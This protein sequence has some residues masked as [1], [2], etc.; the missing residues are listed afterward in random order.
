MA[1]AS[2]A[3]ASAPEPEE[4]YAFDAR[5]NKW[6]MPATKSPIAASLRPA[7]WSYAEWMK[8]GIGALHFVGALLYILLRGSSAPEAGSKWLFTLNFVVWRLAYNVG[9]GWLL[10]HQSNGGW[11]TE[12][13]EKH[14]SGN[15]L[16]SRLLN[17]MERDS[18]QAGAKNSADQYPVTFRSWLAFRFFVDAILA[19][20][21]AA[22]AA[23]CLVHWEVPSL[24]LTTVLAYAIGGFLCFFGLWAKMDS[25]R[26]VRDFAWYWGDFFFLLHSG[27]ELTFD[28]VFMLSPHP[29]YTIGYSFFYGAALITQSHTVLYVSLLGHLCQLAFLQYVENPH[30]EKIYPGVVTHKDVVEAKDKFKLL[31]EAKE[32]YFRRD[33]IA[34]KNFNPVR[35]SDVAL[36]VLLSYNVVT[37]FVCV[38]LHTESNAPYLKLAFGIH[39]LLWRF[40]LSGGLGY[41]LHLQSTR[42]WFVKRFDTPQ[43]AFES[44]KQLY[45]MT[46]VMSYT[47]FI[48]AALFGTF[49]EELPTI[50]GGLA[51]F[52]WFTLRLVLAGVLIAV[53]LWSSVSTYQVVGDFGAF[54]GDFFIDPRGIESQ[55]YYTGIYRFVNDPDLTAGF[56]AF[57]GFAVLSNSFLIFFLAL[58][59]QAAHALFVF[60][61][62]RPHMRFMYGAERVRE[63]SGVAQALKQ[64]W[65]ENLADIPVLAGAAKKV[66]NV[67]DKV[68]ENLENVEQ[69]VL[70]RVRSRSSSRERQEGGSKKDD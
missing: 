60:Y 42:K 27:K 35:A 50:F 54:Y 39:A 65:D 53:N 14:L 24:S 31:Y 66:I 46:L 1:D 10:Y 5:G 15:G 67:K 37:F 41:L 19:T 63:E 8:N 6:K 57:Y 47:S 70:N 12:F 58:V 32:G 3:A 69:A 64:V 21:F 55:L 33:M 62:E 2:A 17:L 44:W 38:G 40:V 20:D 43:L 52:S 29:M 56:A 4:G 18:L 59:A 28:R 13:V 30:I 61:V 48:Q 16:L 7:E 68:R 36:A 11:V 23:F 51:D 9:I 25:Y 34:F 49:T 22:Y 26:V 45:N